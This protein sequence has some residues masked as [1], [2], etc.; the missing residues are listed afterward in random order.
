MYSIGFTT[1]HWHHSVY[2]WCNLGFFFFLLIMNKGCIWTFHAGLTLKYMHSILFKGLFA[3]ITCLQQLFKAQSTKLCGGNW[4]LSRPSPSHGFAYKG[5]VCLW[6]LYWRRERHTL[7]RIREHV[8]L[9]R[10][11]QCLSHGTRKL[12]EQENWDQTLNLLKYCMVFI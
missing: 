11:Q 4:L 12:R 9:I 5:E 6:A 1:I 7:L 8:Q 2:Q 3:T 10:Q